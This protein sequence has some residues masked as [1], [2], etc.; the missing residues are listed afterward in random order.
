MYDVA[1]ETPLE[2]LKIAFAS[3][4]SENFRELAVPLV[5]QLSAQP[6]GQEKVRD[7]MAKADREKT[8]KLAKAVEEALVKRRL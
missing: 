2:V 3:D 6:G 7:V 4:K 1:R 8:E 5:E